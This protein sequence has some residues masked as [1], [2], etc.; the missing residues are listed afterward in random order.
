MERDAVMKKIWLKY[1]WLKIGLPLVIGVLLAGTSSGF[2]AEPSAEPAGDST[3]EKLSTVKS[4]AVKSQKVILVVGAPGAQEYGKLFESWA[5]QWKSAI[6]SSPQSGIVLATIG[7]DPNAKIPDRESLK[8]EIANTPESTEELWIVLMGHGTDDRKRSKFNL[9]GPD[10]SATE[11]DQWLAPLPCRVVLINCSSASGSFIT[12]LKSPR[13]IV[14]TATRSGA[15]HNFA[16]FGGFLAESIADVSLDLDKDQQTSLLEAFIAASARTQEFYVEDTRLASELAMID[17]NSDGLGTPADWFEGT[18]VVRKS[19]KGEPDGLAA[20]Q[21]FLIR[22]GKEAE[23]S[24]ES[25]NRRDKLEVQL[26]KLRSMKPAM[27]PD[28]Y[29]RAIEPVLIELANLYASVGK[30]Q[31]TP[32][33]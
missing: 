1:R 5:E 28:A 23:L 32:D 8:L 17:D 11:L 18:R 2:Q 6:E 26:E 27:D 25:R 22:R 3:A 31:E 10:V 7:L 19:K 30:E 16:R 12:K 4:P 20:N 14:I 9:R 15:Q 29:Y 24:T 21:I 13:R 33:R